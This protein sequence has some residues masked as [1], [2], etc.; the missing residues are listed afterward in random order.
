MTL[1]DGPEVL[2]IASTEYK[3]TVTVPLGADIV[4]GVMTGNTEGW[5]Y[6]IMFGQPSSTAP[7]M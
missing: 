7:I 4:T 1:T 6:L 3:F 5:F 2:I